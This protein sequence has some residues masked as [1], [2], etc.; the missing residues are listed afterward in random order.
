MTD[1]GYNGVGQLTTLSYPEAHDQSW[2]RLEVGYTYQNGHLVAL[3]QDG[4]NVWEAESI[5]PE[6]FV[7]LVRLATVGK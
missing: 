4:S 3:T 5:T 6:G 7:D 2:S 1:Y